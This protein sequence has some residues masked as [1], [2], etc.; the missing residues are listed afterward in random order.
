MTPQLLAVLLIAGLLVSA[1]AGPRVL[2][3]AAPSLMRVPRLT[4]GLLT[5]GV[6]AWVLTL[7]AVGPV[8]AWMLSVPTWLP[9]RA[10][11]VCEQCLAS[12]NPF[13]GRTFDTGLPAVVL[14]AL[15]AAAVVLHC[16][17]VLIEAMRRHRGTLRTAARYRQISETQRL[18]GYEVLLAHDRNPF[19]LSLPRRHGG[20]VI[21]TGAVDLLSADEIVAVLAHEHA[22]L[23]QRHHL[24][25]AVVAGL[26]TR[27]RWIPLLA[28]AEGALGHYLEI[29]ADDHARQRAGRPTLA[30]ALLLLGEA[31]RHIEQV[32]MVEEGALHALGPDRIGHLVQPHRGAA[33]VAAAAASACCLVM[34][35]ALAASIHIPYA[36]AAFSGCV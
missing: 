32:S 11:Q 17:S 3:H 29:A 23:Q 9:P 28:A 21:S 12:A 16:A 35:I 5:G 1:L 34:L 27:L 15:P 2:R 33:G 10:A 26:T 13:G 22:H 6:V 36:L 20:I 18:Y 14:L 4:A 8:L 30:S 24:I 19:A 25:T 31:G 7:L